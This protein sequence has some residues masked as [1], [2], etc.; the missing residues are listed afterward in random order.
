MVALKRNP[1]FFFLRKNE[2]VCCLKEFPL[3]FSA[4]VLLHNPRI[5]KASDSKTYAQLSGG[6]GMY[7]RKPHRKRK[8][9]IRYQEKEIS[10]SP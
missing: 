4:N 8:I 6:P 2:N 9:C 5:T 10:I 7:Q 3:R 1:L